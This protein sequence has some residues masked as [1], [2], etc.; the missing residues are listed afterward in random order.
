MKTLK[1]ASFGMVALLALGMTSCL[2]HSDPE[3]GISG[4]TYYALQRNEILGEDTVATFAP[5]VM[6]LSNEPSTKVTVTSPTYMFGL[7]MKNLSDGYVWETNYDGYYGGDYNKFF[8]SS[9]SEETY[10][11]RMTNAEGKVAQT[12]FMLGVKAEDALGV[13]NPQY[14][15]DVTKGV[16]IKWES[17]KNANR[18]ELT[19]WDVDVENKVVVDYVE[20]SNATELVFNPGEAMQFGFQKGKTYKFVLSAWKVVNNRPK[21]KLNSDDVYTIPAWGE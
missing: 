4:G 5:Y 21:I 1:K 18:Y 12:T 10:T 3:F 8:H 15:Y 9:L 7:P 19:A 20:G 11:I 16:T 14:T 2:N 17:V 6:V 13:L